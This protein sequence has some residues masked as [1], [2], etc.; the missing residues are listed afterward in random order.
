MAN[1]LSDDFKPPELLPDIGSS[2]SDAA[3]EAF[4]KN[5]LEKNNEENLQQAE[6]EESNRLDENE[7]QNVGAVMNQRRQEDR[8][9]NKSTKG[10]QQ[11]KETEKIIKT[12]N[13]RLSK[14]KKIKLGA[15]VSDIWF[16]ISASIGF[17]FPLWWTIIL[18]IIEFLV[19]IPGILIFVA[20]G[21]LKGPV[22]KRTDKLIKQITGEIKEK[23]AQLAKNQQK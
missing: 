19:I 8:S 5:K 22:T 1:N 15:K 17:T 4:N 14:L 12:L 21:I 3:E 10:T 13:S 18:F 20:L 11:D 9:S 23:Q 16:F 7:Q 6:Q 2:T